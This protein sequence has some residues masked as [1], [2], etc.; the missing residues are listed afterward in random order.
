[1]S[2][3]LCG[4]NGNCGMQGDGCPI[5]LSSMCVFYQ[6]NV[7]LDKIN[8]IR[9]ERLENILR[10]INEK[11]KILD[12]QVLEGFFGENVGGGVKI[13]KGLIPNTNRGAIRTLVSTTSILVDN[14]EDTISFSVKDSFMNGVVDPIKNLVS[15]LTT[16]V[17]SLESSQETQNTLITAL[18]VEQNKH[19][20]QIKDLEDRH[21]AVESDIVILHQKVANNAADIAALQAKDRTHDA[22][23]KEIRDE[24]ANLKTVLASSTNTYRESYPGQ[25]IFVTSKGIKSIV[26]VFVGGVLVPDY[27]YTFDAPNRVAILTSVLGITIDPTDSVDI[28][29]TSN[30]Q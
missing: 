24:V 14:S 25:K 26:G 5:N 6:G 13:Y 16:R 1:M 2:N 28:I 11:F 4:N 7:A 30:V 22:D 8:A 12:D 3:C 9:G 18:E 17:E 19:T 15:A 23:I 21:A 27:A 29:Y 20:V 10:N